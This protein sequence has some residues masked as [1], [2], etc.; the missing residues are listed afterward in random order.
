MGSMG[1]GGNVGS[2]GGLDINSPEFAK[3]FNSLIRSIVRDELKKLVSS[4]LRLEKVGKVAVNGS[5]PTVQVYINDSA[6]AVTVKNPRGF[7]LS[8]GQLVA[9]VF[10]NFKNDG[11]KYV[12][13]IL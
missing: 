10:P 2:A 9:V 12:D 1:S 13:R 5:G 8:A 7:S 4:D 3:Q 6:T 11:A